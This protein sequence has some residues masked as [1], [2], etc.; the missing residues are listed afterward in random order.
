MKA[1]DVFIKIRAPALH[2]CA[3]MLDQAAVIDLLVEEG[4]DIELSWVAGSA[5][6]ISARGIKL[7]A[8]RAVLDHGASR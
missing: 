2:D 3:V 6:F 5:L 8:M 7:R 4:A 1:N